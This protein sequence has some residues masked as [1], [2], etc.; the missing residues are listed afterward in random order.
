MGF[1]YE[2]PIVGTP[3]P[4]PYLATA[5]VRASEPILARPGMVFQFHPNFFVPGRGAAV[6]GDMILVNK[7]GCERLTNFRR[8]LLV[9]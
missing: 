7:S 6:I 8:E 3:F 5:N 2:E 9:A 1:F 4:Q